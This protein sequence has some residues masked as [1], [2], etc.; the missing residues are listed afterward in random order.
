MEKLLKE[1]GVGGG[2]AAVRGCTDWMLE[3]QFSDK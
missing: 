1:C 3:Q 2:I